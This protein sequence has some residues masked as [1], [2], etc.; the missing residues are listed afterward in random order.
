MTLGIPALFVILGV[1]LWRV[2]EGRRQN[3]V[4]LLQA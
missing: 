2:R 3:A 1:I 4:A